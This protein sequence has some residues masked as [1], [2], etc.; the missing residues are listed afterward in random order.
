MGIQIKLDHG[1]AKPVVVCDYCG[2]QIDDAR[3][4][5]YQWSVGDRGELADDAP[6]V[7]T[8]RSCCQAFE[9]AHGGRR[10]WA[11]APLSCLP[12][13][14]AANL[15]LTLDDSRQRALEMSSL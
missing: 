3:T 4:G 13:F 9:S 10:R 14:L 12:T 11:W 6:V 8:H 7:F 15:R 2:E 5:N 1:R